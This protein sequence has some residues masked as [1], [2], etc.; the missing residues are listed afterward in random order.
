MQCANAAQ[1]RNARKVFERAT[2]LGVKSVGLAGLG[3]GMDK[4]CWTDS[5]SL[6]SGVSSD[7]SCCDT[8]C[9]TSCHAS[10]DTDHMAG[11]STDSQLDQREAFSSGDESESDHAH[12][13]QVRHV[14]L[15]FRL[16]P[17]TSGKTE[18]PPFHPQ[19]PPVTPVRGADG[20]A[21]GNPVSED[22]LQKIRA[23]GTTVTYFGGEVI[24]CSGAG[25]VRSPMT[26]AIMEEIRRSARPITLGLGASLGIKFRL[27]K[28]NSCG[29]RLELAGQT[30]GGGHGGRWVRATPSQTAAPTGAPRPRRSS[31]EREVDETVV[32]NPTLRP[33]DAPAPAASTASAASARKEP[34]PE[35]AA[36]RADKEDLGVHHQDGD[37]RDDEHLIVDDLHISATTQVAASQKIVPQHALP[38]NGASEKATRQNGVPE[39]VIL[40]NGVNEKAT[41]QNGAADRANSQNGAGEKPAFEKVTPHNGVAEKVTRQNGASEKIANGTSQKGVAQ[42]GTEDKEN[43]PVAPV[44]GFTTTWKMASKDAKRA[45]VQLPA[46][47]PPQPDKFGVME[48]EEFQFIDS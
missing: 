2:P 43:R 11:G 44:A 45:V 8:S 10:C 41:A 3:L 48:F 27:V 4:R 24:A 35:D 30:A 20:E 14:I 34:T 42:I 32:R 15:V 46:M 12:Q 31:A 22:V 38:R 18:L 29:S 19:P 26:M 9:H 21:Q 23:C 13:K 6:S 47:P 25:P 33:G 36:K 17:I 1:V 28:S 40:Q 16:S 39:K 37:L 5:G 7:L